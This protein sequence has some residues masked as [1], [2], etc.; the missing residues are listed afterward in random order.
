MPSLMINS[1]LIE[2]QLENMNLGGSSEEDSESVE[3]NI[4]K[5]GN[6]KKY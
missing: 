1:D 5:V 3:T 2:K 6:K 4:R